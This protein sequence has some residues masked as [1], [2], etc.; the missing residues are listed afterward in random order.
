MIAL[1]PPD[2]IGHS[3]INREVNRVITTL[4]TSDITGI[5]SHNP[6]A[7]LTRYS[8]PESA[9]Q[10]QRFQRNRSTFLWEILLG[11]WLGGF[12]G[13]A[14]PIEFQKITLETFSGLAIVPWMLWVFLVQLWIW[15]RISKLY[16]RSVFQGF[17]IWFSSSNYLL[18]QLE[19]PL[20]SAIPFSGWN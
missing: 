1:W 9:I 10:F 2:H 16:S 13:D 12:L 7:G 14:F 8:F 15:K 3:Q 19:P 6:R 4:W 17:G 5:I 18:P 20:R 11:G